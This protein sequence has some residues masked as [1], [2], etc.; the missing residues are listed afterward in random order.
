MGAQMGLQTPRSAL[1]ASTSGGLAPGQSLP[2]PRGCGG[3]RAARGRHWEQEAQ[4]HPRGE[5]RILRRKPPLESRATRAAR[6]QE[7]EAAQAGQPQVP[8]EQW[9]FSRQARLLPPTRC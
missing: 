1:A 8:P 9:P 3:L 2:K 6:A 4:G 5:G 7:F